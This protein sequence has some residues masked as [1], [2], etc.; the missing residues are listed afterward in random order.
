MS[1][2]Y[3]IVGNEKRR[4][5][6]DLIYNQGRTIAQAAKELNIFYATAKAINNVYVISGRQDKKAKRNKKRSRKAVVMQN[7]ILQMPYSLS[8]VSHPASLANNQTPFIDT[9]M[10]P[11]EQNLPTQL[12]LKGIYG[13][14]KDMFRVNDAMS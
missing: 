11:F 7:T 6:I 13:S 3:V 12:G 5:V 8:D 10:T 1:K 14:P 2:K 4:Q 9:T